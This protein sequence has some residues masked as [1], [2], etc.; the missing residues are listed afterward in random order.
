MHWRQRITIAILAAAGLLA[1]PA[2]EMSMSVHPGPARDGDTRVA[3]HRDASEPS[4]AA[5]PDARDASEATPAVDRVARER[6]GSEAVLFEGGLT[7][8][9]AHVQLTAGPRLGSRGL[10]GQVDTDRTTPPAAA[11][12]PDNLSQI[13]FTSEG[14]DFDP[15]VDPAGEWLVYASTRHRATAGLFLK[16]VNGTT[17]TQLTNDPANDVTPAFSPDG[18][19]IAFASDRSGQFDIYIMD[20]RGGQPVQITHD[21]THDI[22]P[23]FSP[24]GDKLV[25]SRFGGPSGQWEMVVIDLDNPGTQ[26]IIG[27]GLFPQWSPV[28]DRIVFQR[29]RQRGTRWFSVWTVELNESGEVSSPTEIAASDNAAVITPRWSPDGEHI[30]FCT[31]VDPPADNAE[32]PARADIWVVSADGRGRARLTNG[33]FANLQ[34]T[35]AADGTIYFVSNRAG[36]ALENIWAVR[37]DRALHLAR[38]GEEGPGDPSASVPV[39]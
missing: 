26:R 3:R 38:P 33:Q 25:Y 1:M 12:G 20:A 31:V 9:D 8:A 36:E 19:R 29:P 30:V 21:A 22:H 10:L 2:C 15:A 27:T 16:R 24:D 14:G 5:T 11:D 39:E 4:S 35:W 7:H 28:D 17:L 6:R 34:P 37:P 32:R 23:T 18:Q 13:T